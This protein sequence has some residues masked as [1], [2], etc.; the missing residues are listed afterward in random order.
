[1][2]IGGRGN[3]NTRA[4]EVC[5]GLFNKPFDCVARINA[6]NSFDCPVLDSYVASVGM[7]NRR[8]GSGLV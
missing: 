3:V 7:L 4:V 8:R 2:P 1:V 6:A 5:L